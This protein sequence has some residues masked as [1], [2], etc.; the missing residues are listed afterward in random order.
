M[1]VDDEV[2][3]LATMASSLRAHGYQV[4]TA[5]DGESALL[6]FREHG[7]NLDLVITDLVLPGMSGWEVFTGIREKSPEM[8]ILIMSGHLEP[9]LEAAVRRSGAS[10]FVQKPFGLGVLLRRVKDILAKSNAA[11]ADYDI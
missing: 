3:F 9:K 4:I 2:G 5:M 11:G 1:I 10:G 6:E 7:E 8:P